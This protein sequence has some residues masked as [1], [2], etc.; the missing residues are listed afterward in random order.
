MSVDEELFLRTDYLCVC[1]CMH[2]GVC[3]SINSERQS[4]KAKQSSL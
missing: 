3:L 2:V 1:V 4:I